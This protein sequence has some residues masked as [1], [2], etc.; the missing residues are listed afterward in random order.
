MT[1][2][3]FWRRAATLIADNEFWLLWL[4]GAPLLISSSLPFWFFAAT[5]CAIPFFWIARR[6]A[7]GH[8]SIATP[9][10][11]PLALLLLLG[12]V[13]V[14]I[15]ID[16]PQSARSYAELVGGAAL[17]FGVVNGLRARESAQVN[18][19]RGISK[20]F[21]IT[22]YLLIGLAL[23][24][25][26]A[27]ALGL[28]WP[29]KF[30]PA[31]IYAYLPKFDFSIFNPRGFTPNIVAGALAPIVP[32]CWLWGWQQTRRRRLTLFG[33]SLTLLTIIV[34][35]QSRGAMIGIVVSV[36]FSALW[37]KPRVGWL[38]AA[39]LIGAVIAFLGVEANRAADF[40]ALDDSTVTAA[41]R[42]ELWSRALYIAQ[43]FPFTGI[44]LGAFSQVVPVMYPLFINSP[45]APL[46]HA[47]N[48]YL[49]MAV[50]YGIG[51]FVCF[52]GMTTTMLALGVTT[53]KRARGTPNALL[54]LGLVAGYIVFLAH[55][56]LDAVFVSS[57]VSV[58]IW[59]LLAL[60]TALYRAL[61]FDASYE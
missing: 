26:L 10:D 35:T 52:I 25:G 31:P 60:L 57:K 18:A 22:L 15:S 34:L 28:R 41:G 51:G 9:L 59:L 17:Y 20:P 29:D 3:L 50:D 8:W 24:M 19:A 1:R 12:L 5:L 27:G 48:M 61:S 11:L 30:L 33:I 58:I 21:T 2:A 53:I 43:D 36:A 13:A 45:D 7:R 4:Y 37:L 46:P 42:F 54:A 14:G 32:L 49:Q 47:H 55:G 38:V 39:L 6:I 56:M 44:G 16:I 23:A 40:A